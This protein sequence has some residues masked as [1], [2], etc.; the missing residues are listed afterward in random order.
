LI[1]EKFANLV[2]MWDGTKRLIMSPEDPIRD[3]EAV[4]GIGLEA[5]GKFLKI[6]YEWSFDGAHQEGFMLF[7]VDKSD[8]AKAVWIDSFHQSGDFMHLIGTFAD[9]K[10]SVKA[11]YTQPEYSDWA[12][13]IVIETESDNSFSFNMFNIFPDG[14][15]APAVETKFKRRD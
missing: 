3:C 10:I 8:N 12:W 2:G 15:E 7:H 1:T 5:N 9:G 11:N 4:A 6:N 13:R 14:T